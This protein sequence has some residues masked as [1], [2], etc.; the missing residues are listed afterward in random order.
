MNNTFVV[1]AALIVI[2]TGIFLIMEL[3]FSN[4][5]VKV[6]SEVV[7]TSAYRYCLAAIKMGVSTPKECEAMLNE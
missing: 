7:N 2:P 1:I 4:S 5:K 3:G 6:T